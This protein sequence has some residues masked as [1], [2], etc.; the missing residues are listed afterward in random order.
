MHHWPRFLLSLSFCVVTVAC[1]DAD[2]LSADE[3]EP[4]TSADDVE[5]LYDRLGTC[6]DSFLTRTLTPRPELQSTSIWTTPSSAPAGLLSWRTASGWSQLALANE[7][8]FDAIAG[9]MRSTE[10]AC[11]AVQRLFTPYRAQ[12]SVRDQ[13]THVLLY[14]DEAEHPY[15]AYPETGIEPRRAAVNASLVSYLSVVY[16]ERVVTS[17]AI[18]Y[19]DVTEQHLPMYVTCAKPFEIETTAAVLDDLDNA[20]IDPAMCDAGFDLDGDGDLDHRCVA[21]RGL[22]VVDNTCTFV[23]DAS[24]LTTLDGE[25]QPALFGGRLRALERG[26]RLTYE[27]TIDRFSR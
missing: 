8:T 12:G 4:P 20:Q 17:E 14:L 21:E 16:A 11:V 25:R 3:L 2:G 13:F 26:D 23:V 24:T 22:H 18:E 27:L 9:E 1:G 5:D 6:D 7:L 10:P 15:S 19:R